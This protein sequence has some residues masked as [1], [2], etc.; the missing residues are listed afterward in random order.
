MKKLF[1]LI[2][3]IFLYANC[4]VQTREMDSPG[5]GIDI[6]IKSIYSARGVK[7]PKDADKEILDKFH[8]LVDLT[9]KKDYS[10]LPSLVNPKRGIYVDLK[11]HWSFNQLK[12]ELK[13]PESYLETF[14]FSQEKLNKET[15]G[16]SYTVRNLLIMAEK[17]EIEL[18]FETEDSCEIKVKF[19][20]N[21]SKEFDLNNPYFIRI[22]GKW[23]LYRLF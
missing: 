11:S 17:L 4:S 13:N 2:I 3:F 10:S 19:L 5:E 8:I 23:Y 1:I 22:D 7:R 21:K 15:G 14:Y 12:E 6:K 20:K 18:F 9:L 16:G